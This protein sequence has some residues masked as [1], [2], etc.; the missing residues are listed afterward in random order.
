MANTLFDKIWD[1][2]I[3]QKVEDGPT[4]VYRRLYCMR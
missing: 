4:V 1:A 3:V 2:H